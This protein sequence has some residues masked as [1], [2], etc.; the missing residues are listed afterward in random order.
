MKTLKTM[1]VV[2]YKDL[3]LNRIGSQAL[4]IPEW[5]RPNRW[6][7]KRLAAAVNAVNSGDFLPPLVLAELGSKLLVVDGGH[8]LRTI[9][10]PDCI[11]A[12]GSIGVCVIK[13][14]TLEEAKELFFTVNDGTKVS[15]ADK[16]YAAAPSIIKAAARSE[17]TSILGVSPKRAAQIVYDIYR[18]TGSVSSIPGIID[19]IDEFCSPDMNSNKHIAAALIL[20]ASGKQLSDVD[21]EDFCDNLTKRDG[22]SNNEITAWF[23]PSLITTRKVG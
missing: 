18:L 2:P 9:Q 6:T 23:S 10:S 1:L 15:T 7:A 3:Q 5:Q 11:S 16:D 4:E 21:F 14:E 20:G 12:N 8:R 13:V 22:Y 17:L 19:I